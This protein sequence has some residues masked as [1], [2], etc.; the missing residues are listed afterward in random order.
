MQEA[1]YKRPESTSFC[2]FVVGMAGWASSF[3]TRQG[4]QVQW[5]NSMLVA[6]DSAINNVLIVD[7]AVHYSHQA[8]SICHGLRSCITTQVLAF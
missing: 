8:H 2:C 3:L 5:K 6:L 4:Q 1:W 7:Q